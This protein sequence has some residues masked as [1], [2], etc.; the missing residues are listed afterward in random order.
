MKNFVSGVTGYRRSTPSLSSSL[1]DGE[2][3]HG[4]LKTTARSINSRGRFNSLLT[5]CII[6][7]ALAILSA[8]NMT[9]QTAGTISGHV[10]DQTGAIVPDASITLKNVGTG[11][12][13]TTLTTGAGEYTFAEVPVG[14]YTLT[15]KAAGFMSESANNVQVQVQQSIRL[16]LSLQVGAVTQSVVVEA[17]GTLLQAENATLGTVIDNKAVNELPLNGRNYLGLV[18]LSS[19]V[20]TLSPG[21]GPGRSRLGGERASQSIAVGGQRIMF[22]YYTLDGVNNTDPD[23]NTYIGLP[24]LDGIQEFKVQTGVYSAEFGHEA[25]QVNVRQQERHQHL[26]RQ[27]VRLHPQQPGRRK[28]LFLPLQ[29]CPSQGVSLQVE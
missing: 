29:C 9:A 27:P 24:S 18:A 12:E 20:N 11:T 4:R 7:F 28:S 1:Q 15:A 23:F 14:V 16:N 8:S 10:S 22:D 5:C 13:R 26:S 2:T 19:N 6:T 21:I 17:T 3:S 25:S